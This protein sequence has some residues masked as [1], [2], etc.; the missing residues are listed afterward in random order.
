MACAMKASTW[1]REPVPSSYGTRL[2]L[3]DKLYPDQFPYPVD[4]IQGW[5]DT[6]F[7]VVISIPSASGTMVDTHSPFCYGCLDASL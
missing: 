4:Y 2:I 1:C 7:E 6:D 5:I 3:Q